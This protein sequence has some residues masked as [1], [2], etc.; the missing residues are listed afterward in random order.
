MDRQEITNA[1]KDIIGD[2]LKNRGLELVDLIYRYEG[3]DLFLRIFADRPTGGITLEECAQINTEISRILDEKDILREGY[4][5]EVSSPGLDRPLKTKNDF[6]RCMNRR[7]KFFL[8]EPVN[9]KIELEGV[10]CQATEGAVYIEIEANTVQIPL[11][12]IKKAK[13]TIGNI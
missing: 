5:L 7:A 11:S 9:G 12:K 13:Q 4:I 8:S 1:L 2:Y 6:L 3:R 10:I